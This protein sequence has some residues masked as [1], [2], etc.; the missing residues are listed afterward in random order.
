L[1]F[2][3]GGRLDETNLAT[4]L[5]SLPS[6]GCVELMCHPGAD[7]MRPVGGWQYS[8]AA[9]RSALTSERIREL[10][11]ERGVTLVSQRGS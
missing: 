11:A 6:A 8:W 4:A 5:G 9:E 7:D 2:Y 1:G 10:L 3:F